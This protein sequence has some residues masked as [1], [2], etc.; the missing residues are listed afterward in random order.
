MKTKDYS[1]FKK[2]LK[3]A[4]STR[5][6]G[7]RIGIKC[8]DDY[9][10]YCKDR[11]RIGAWQ[12]I[13]GHTRRGTMFSTLAR[14]P[15]VVN[16]CNWTLHSQIH[17]EWHLLKVVWLFT[18]PFVLRGSARSWEAPGPARPPRRD[19][20][21]REQRRPRWL[22]FQVGSL[23]N[24]EYFCIS[25]NFSA[26]VFIHLPSWLKCVPVFGDSKP[27]T[28]RCLSF[29]NPGKKKDVP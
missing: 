13:C 9:K 28:N 11:Q 1:K 23:N 29:S 22:Q 24:E 4:T 3:G 15:T 25:Q 17:S 6:L 10:D 7:V 16:Y 20:P 27:T 18:D 26:T 5:V 2:I 19:P 12:C 21:V 8:V 14:D